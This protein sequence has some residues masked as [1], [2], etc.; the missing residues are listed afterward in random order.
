M[1]T[2]FLS[3][4]VNLLSSFGWTQDP[5]GVQN[6]QAWGTVGGAWLRQSFTPTESISDPEIS[7]PCFF[8]TP[9][10]MRMSLYQ[11]SVWDENPV[12]IGSSDV[13]NG[14]DNTEYSQAVWYSMSVP[15]QVL[16]GGQQYF[17]E[18]KDVD[19]ITPTTI[20]SFGT[21]GEEDLFVGGEE[22]DPLTPY[23]GVG[24]W[25]PDLEIIVQGNCVPCPGDFN[26]D[27]MVGVADLVMF[28]GSFSC[29][30]ECNQDLDIDGDTIIGIGDLVVFVS[31]FG[32]MCP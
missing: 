11:G 27:G 13:W 7:I 24:Y 4:I 12:F 5:C 22:R 31:F 9:T 14:S 18:I 29:T 20:F 26:Q 32:Q 3:V 1:R 8:V 17:L 30:F 2:T 28:V 6:L 23:I 19:P 25:F 16:T 10:M 15:G 21:T